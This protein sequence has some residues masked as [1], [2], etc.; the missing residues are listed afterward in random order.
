MTPQEERLVKD[1]T[2][3]AE[4]AFGVTIP[5]GYNPDIQFMAHL[6]EDLRCVH[7][8]LCF[9]LLMIAAVV[10]TDILVLALGFKKRRVN[11]MTF[12]VK[13]PPSTRKS[14][15]LEAARKAWWIRL[16]IA[17]MRKLVLLVADAAWAMRQLVYE[18]L[19]QA[20][21]AYTLSVE[22]YV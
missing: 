5:P 2:A 19:L 16:P 21:S 7:K 8:P 9:Y 4:S 18:Q 6:Y 11:G 10:S 14:G 13:R 20:L 15:I 17:L 3:Q 1:M 22:S 12:W